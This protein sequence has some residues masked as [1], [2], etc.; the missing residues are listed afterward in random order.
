M[1]TNLTRKNVAYVLEQPD[2]QPNRIRAWP[3]KS[4]ELP[5]G[6]II[7]KAP[8]QSALLVLDVAQV[9]VQVGSTIRTFPNSHTDSQGRV[10]WYVRAY[11]GDKKTVVEGWT[12]KNE[13]ATSYLEPLQAIESC[14]A[15]TAETPG[16]RWR[17][18]NLKAGMQAYVVTQKLNLRQ[19]PS[20][21]T[22]DVGD[23]FA[24]AVVTVLEGPHCS[25]DGRVWWRIKHNGHDRWVCENEPSSA[26]ADQIEWN[27][28]PVRVT[29]PPD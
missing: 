16:M 22:A 7:G 6:P 4:P 14:N 28:L 2:V 8:E 23:L 1:S 25:A 24:G 21:A 18:S 17:P 13:G 26:D 15:A 20:I 3:Q 5:E 11:D 27:L 29:L 12:A 9:S 19:G 10:W